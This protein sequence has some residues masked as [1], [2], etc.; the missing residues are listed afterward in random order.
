M[1]KDV[2]SPLGTFAN[3]PMKTIKEMAYNAA[4]V[5]DVLLA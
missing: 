1:S 3:Y 5:I 4:N 2:F